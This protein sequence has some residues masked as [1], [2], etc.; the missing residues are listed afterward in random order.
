VEPIV[1]GVLD[2]VT[3]RIRSEINGRVG[4]MF[5]LART[6]APILVTFHDE[7]EPPK[8]AI[9]PSPEDKGDFCSGIRDMLHWA[10]ANQ[11]M[12]IPPFAAEIH[13]RFTVLRPLA[14]A[15]VRGA[16]DAGLAF[17]SSVGDGT[18]PI[19]IAQV[20]RSSGWPEATAQITGYCK[21]KAGD[22]PSLPAG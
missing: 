3:H 21:L 13:R 19:L 20:L 18:N 15:P 5:T 16:V 22:F 8:S 14:R 10:E 2:P 1:D 6:A 4:W 9:T 11:E 12:D 7:P 17:Y